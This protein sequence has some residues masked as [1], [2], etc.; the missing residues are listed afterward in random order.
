MVPGRV[1]EISLIN[2]N[3]EDMLKSDTEP[4]NLTTLYGKDPEQFNPYHSPSW[5]EQLHRP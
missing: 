2:P 1:Q 5:P 3:M 4:Q